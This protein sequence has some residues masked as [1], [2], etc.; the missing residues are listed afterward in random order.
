MSFCARKCNWCDCGVWREAAK[1]GKD[2]SPSLPLFIRWVLECVLPPAFELTHLETVLVCVCVC[3]FSLCFTLLQSGHSFKSSM[4][5][6]Q[7]ECQTLTSVA[8]C[9]AVR[10]GYLFLSCSWA[11][12]AGWLAVCQPLLA[13]HRQRCS[14]EMTPN[15]RRQRQPL[16]PDASEATVTVPARA[17][18]MDRCMPPTLMAV[19]FA[20]L[21][22][23]SRTSQL[24]LLTPLRAKS[25]TRRIPL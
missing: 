15:Q 17:K 18:P 22:S 12:L 6:S 4:R 24:L 7:R 3:V 21:R 20:R 16:L 13:C 19:T 25:R 2:L 5:A 8:L 9:F 1:K 11:S 14:N 10:A 23:P